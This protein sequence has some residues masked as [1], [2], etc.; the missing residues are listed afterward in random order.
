MQRF[1]LS[2]SLCFFLS[3]CGGGGSNSEPVSPPPPV[4]MSFA[5]GGTV[6]GLGNAGLILGNGGIT[7]DVP[8]NSNSFT[9]KDHAPTGTSYQLT[10]VRQPYG[11]IDACTLSNASGIVGSADVQNITVSCH[12]AQAM[13]TGFAGQEDV[14][15]VVVGTGIGVSPVAFAMDLSGNVYISDDYSY[16]IRKLS[17]SGQLSVLAGAGFPGYADGN[18]SAAKFNGAGSMVTDSSGN[19]YVTDLYNHAIRKIGPDGTVTT[20]AGNGKAGDMD[21]K[22][23]EAQFNLP[24][25]LAI[26]ATGNLFVS[27]PQSGLIRKVTPDGI[28]STFAGGP[29]CCY[30]N[31]NGNLLSLNALTIDSSGN[32]YGVDTTND[33]V[34][35]ITP[36]KVVT[37]LAGSGYS[38]N[39]VD[40]TGTKASFF[41]PNSIAVDATGMLYVAENQLVRKI[42]RDGVVTTLAGGGSS[43][44]NTGIGPTVKFSA[45]SDIKIDQLGNVYVLGGGRYIRKISSQ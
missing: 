24:Q 32:L 5:I 13:V 22:G 3:A 44:N 8:P 18:G 21:G 14:G 26:D 25:G 40:G 23:T 41:N 45:V 6:S 7:L 28:V 33:L 10:V 43:L 2:A 27:E 12:P 17:A 34:I 30:A 15:G 35:K 16:V 31:G 1:I 38:A 29:Q 39:S 9:F 11:F 19:L 36:S 37:I 4:P 42:T 20:L